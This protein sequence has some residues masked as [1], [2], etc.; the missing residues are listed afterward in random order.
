MNQLHVFF[1]TEFDYAGV[2]WLMFSSYIA[3]SLIIKVLVRRTGPVAIGQYRLEE[4]YENDDESKLNVMYRMFSPIVWSNIFILVASIVLA[5]IN[6]TALSMRWL[7]VAYYWI[8]LAYNK[9]KRRNWDISRPAFVLEAATSIIISIMFD[10]CVVCKV[11]ELGIAALDQ[12]ALGFQMMTMVCYAVV[13]FVVS[14]ATRKKYWLYIVQPTR[15]PFAGFETTRSTYH[16]YYRSRVNLSEKQ[17]F[18]YERSYG[19]LLPKRYKDDVLLRAIFFSIMAIEDSNRPS[20]YRALER[21]LCKLGHAKTTGIMQQKS[22]RPLTDEESVQLATRYIEDMWDK[23]LSNYSRYS[24]GNGSADV[25]SFGHNWYRYRYEDL[26]SL[27]CDTFSSLYGDY[28]GTRE[29]RTN[30]V[31]KRVLSFVERNHYD[32]KPRYISST[33]VL[34]PDE[35]SWFAAEP[36]YWKDETTISVQSSAKRTETPHEATRKD[37]A[38]TESIDEAVGVLNGLQADVIQVSRIEPAI[39]IVRFYCATDRVTIQSALPGEWNVH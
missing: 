6:G 32:L 31:F 37:K 29:L 20:G 7:P 10:W 35:T 19:S 12:S 3:A 33:A 18:T 1:E 16:T 9:T 13:Q 14:S 28:C 22:N 26:A 30:F 36:L 15:H 5:T 38:T 25:F 2:N 17:L 21:L 23:Y 27:L 8:I 4:L 11:P 24:Y 39:C 34:F